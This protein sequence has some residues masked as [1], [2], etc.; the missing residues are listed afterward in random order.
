MMMKETK[1]L[2]KTMVI[3]IRNLLLDQP[4]PRPNQHLDGAG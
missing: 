2:E 4:P 1:K 3:K